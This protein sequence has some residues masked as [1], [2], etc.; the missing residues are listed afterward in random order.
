MERKKTTAKQ[1]DAFRNSVIADFGNKDINSKT[2]LKLFMRDKRYRGNKPPTQ[3]QVNLAFDFLM[4]KY[5]EEIEFLSKMGQFSKYVNV[6]TKSKYYR[7]EE[8]IYINGKLYR[9]GQFLPRD[10]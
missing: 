5:Q 6:K 3:K 7:A 2:A 4:T 8:N 1:L 10:K 9:K